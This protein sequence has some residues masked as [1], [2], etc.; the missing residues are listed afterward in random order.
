MWI[1]RNIVFVREC[2]C[3]S[4]RDWVVPS[5]AH[6]VLLW[7]TTPSFAHRFLGICFLDEYVT[8]QD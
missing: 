6:Y 4:E 3:N 1:G 7:G 5:C 8:D 2:K